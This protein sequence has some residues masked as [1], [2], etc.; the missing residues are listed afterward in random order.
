MDPARAV[1]RRGAGRAAGGRRGV[2]ALEAPER[3]ALEHVLRRRPAAGR[4]LL[5]AGAR[6]FAAALFSAGVHRRTVRGAETPRRGMRRNPARRGG[7]DADA[8]DLRL[9]SRGHRKRRAVP[10]P[11]GL[12]EPPPGGV[13]SGGRRRRVPDLG[14]GQPQ[15]LRGE[16]QLGQS[17]RFVRRPLFVPDRYGRAESAVPR[18]VRSADRIAA[19]LPPQPAATL[20]LGLPD[21]VGGRI[22]CRSAAHVPAAGGGDRAHGRIRNRPAAAPFSGRPEIPGRMFRAGRAGRAGGGLPAAVSGLVCDPPDH[23]GAAAGDHGRL[24]GQRLESAGVEQRARKL[25]RT[26]PPHRAAAARPRGAETA[27]GQP[28]RFHDRQH[29]LRSGDEN[30]PL[31]P[32]HSGRTRCHARH[33]VRARRAGR[34]AGRRNPV[35]RLHPPAAGAGSEKAAADSFCRAGVPVSEFLALHSRHGK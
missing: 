9:L 13:F 34:A 6:L 23:P 7:G 12:P 17:D 15:K 26:A 24:S 3:R 11:E 25:P 28:G 14:A 4:A 8:A 32:G 5:A 21:S 10:V 29:V 19:R 20:A 27:R 16:P 30:S 31:R 35:P 2:R 33:A 1:P 18:P 22:Q